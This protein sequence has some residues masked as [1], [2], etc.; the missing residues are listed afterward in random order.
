MT[1]MPASPRTVWGEKDVLRLVGDVLMEIRCES[2][3]LLGGVLAPANRASGLRVLPAECL[4]E[5]LDGLAFYVRERQLA[6]EK[7]TKRQNKRLWRVCVSGED[8]MRR[9]RGVDE[10]R[11]LSFRLVTAG[12]MMGDEVPTREDTAATRRN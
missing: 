2:G 8:G 11:P 7:K 3:L 1:N 4:R 9:G 10:S 12:G 5:W 6:W